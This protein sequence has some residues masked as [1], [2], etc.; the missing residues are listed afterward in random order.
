MV[1]LLRNEETPL[2]SGAGAVRS[3]HRVLLSKVLQRFVVVPPHYV[4]V[5]ARPRPRMTLTADRFDLWIPPQL[6][7]RRAFTALPKSLGAS[8]QPEGQIP[9]RGLSH[10]PKPESVRQ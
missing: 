10:A 1:A 2:V 5:W 4:S 6:H 9:R 8:A 7:A 3:S